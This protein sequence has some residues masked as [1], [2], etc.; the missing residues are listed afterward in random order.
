[1]LLSQ[2]FNS[3]FRHWPRRHLT[4][5]EQR[6][7]TRLEEVLFIPAF[8][9]LLFSRSSTIKHFYKSSAEVCSG[10]IGIFLM[11][12]NF[13]LKEKNEM[14]KCMY[15]YKLEL[16]TETGKKSE[17]LG[18]TPPSSNVCFLAGEKLDCTLQYQDRHLVL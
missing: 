6:V 7:V 2:N 11:L 4:R 5:D 9:C 16:L 13:A 12:S 1:M 14:G 8:L 3:K 18:C 10:G 17:R 15:N